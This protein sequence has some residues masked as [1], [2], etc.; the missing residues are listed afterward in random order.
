MI[1]FIQRYDFKVALVHARS[2]NQ[3]IKIF[4]NLIANNEKP[5]SG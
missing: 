4:S 5:I 1:A 2:M 3:S